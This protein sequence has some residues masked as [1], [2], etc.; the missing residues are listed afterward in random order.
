[1]PEVV[2]FKAAFGSSPPPRRPVNPGSYSPLP[3]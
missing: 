1:V 2:S 3:M